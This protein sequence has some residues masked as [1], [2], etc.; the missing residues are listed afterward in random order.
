MAVLHGNWRKEEYARSERDR[1]RREAEQRA[2]EERGAREWERLKSEV[3]AD[4]EAKAEVRAAEA[5]RL[6]RMGPAELAAHYQ[7]QQTEIPTPPPPRPNG[8]W[9]A[10]E[11]IKREQADSAREQREEH[12]HADGTIARRENW[13]AAQAA[14][15]AKLDTDLQAE[16]ERHEKA[17]KGINRDAQAAL[18]QLGARP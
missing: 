12:E 4:L 1:Q 13:D 10:V 6:V 7:R 2:T 18:E 8:W 9:L 11:E 5:T 15:A 16:R 17:M 3:R 14:I